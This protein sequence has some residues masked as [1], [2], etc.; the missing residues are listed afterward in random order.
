[1]RSRGLETAEGLGPYGDSA[2]RIGH[3]GDIRLE[4]VERTLS[5]LKDVL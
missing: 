1:M 3:M 2:F 5:A 4:D